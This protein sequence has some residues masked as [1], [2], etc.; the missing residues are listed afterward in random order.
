MTTKLN[1]QM[2]QKLVDLDCNHSF[3][4]VK[5]AVT[6][7]GDDS[8]E[9][10]LGQIVP[11]VANVKFVVTSL[12]FEKLRGECG[13]VIAHRDTLFSINN[14]AEVVTAID[15]LDIDAVSVARWVS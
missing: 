7:F 11:F 15:G 14:R 13:K 1:Y 12:A 4:V 3:E 8:S 10:N 2:L 9:I 6:R 5:V